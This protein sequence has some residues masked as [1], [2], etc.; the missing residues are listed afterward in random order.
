MKAVCEAASGVE[1]RAMG[2]YRSWLEGRKQGSDTATVETVQ[3]KKRSSRTGLFG[4]TVTGQRMVF[5]LDVS[6]SMDTVDRVRRR[7]PQ[8]ARTSVGA[9]KGRQPEASVSR[10]ERAKKQLVQVIQRLGVGVRFN[11]VTFSSPQEVVPWR[12]GLIA[13]SAEAK[14][15]ARQY[16]MGL[17]AGG[18]TATD[19]A[20]ETAFARRDA[21][22]IYLISDGVPTHLGGTKPGDTEALMVAISRRVRELNLL[23]DVRV[24]TLGFPQVARGYEFLA[25]LARENGGRFI[26]IEPE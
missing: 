13:V 4:L 11:I 3:G 8:R 24:F 2:D 19:V 26:K 21:D 20:L 7:A 17:R 14:A 18:V 23:R 22:S 16:V 5:V 9:S 12:E 6:G 1:L 15:E 10:L 25:E